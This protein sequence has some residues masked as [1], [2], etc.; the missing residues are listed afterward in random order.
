MEKLIKEGINT[1]TK[2]ETE[3]LWYCERCK[4]STFT[5]GRMCPCPRGSCDAKIIGTVT[6]ITTTTTKIELKK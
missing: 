3:D 2:T 6:T 1:T 5:E 4:I